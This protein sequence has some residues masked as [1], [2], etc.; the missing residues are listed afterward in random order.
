MVSWSRRRGPGHGELVK[1][2]P[3]HGELVKRGAWTW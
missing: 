2:G 1:R 3:G